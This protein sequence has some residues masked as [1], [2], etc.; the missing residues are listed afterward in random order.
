VER[1]KVKALSS[2]PTTT[3]KS[4]KIKQKRIRTGFISKE[5]RLH[6]EKRITG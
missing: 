5:E 4:N 1:V 2:R 6:Q 3:K